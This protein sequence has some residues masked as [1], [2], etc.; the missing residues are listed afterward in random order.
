VSQVFKSLIQMRFLTYKY[1]S[2]VSQHLGS[3]T[4]MIVPSLK[5]IVNMGPMVYI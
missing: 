2:K 3:P 4:M 1:M 5:S